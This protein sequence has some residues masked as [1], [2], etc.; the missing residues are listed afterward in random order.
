MD[1]SELLGAG[2]NNPVFSGG[3]GLAILAV[4][5]SALRSSARLSLDLLKRHFVISLEVTSKDKAYPWILQWISKQGS[6]T[7]HLSVDTVV[8]NIGH[9]TVQ[10]SFDF[11]PGPG[12]HFIRYRGHFMSVQRIREQQMVDLNTGKPWEKVVFL[13]LGRSTLLF[14]S[15]LREA[16]DNASQQEEGKMIIFTNW[17]AEWRPFGQPRRRRPLDSVILDEGISKK[18]FDDVTNWLSAEKWYAERGIPYRRGYLL[19]GPPGSG[20]TSYIMVKFFILKYIINDF[21]LILL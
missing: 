11:V 20:K 5:A 14:E 17:G 1:F 9:N 15:I 12:Q 16:Y 2:S 21:E 10:T 8:R 6:R 13:S 19:H 7:Q 3:F 18:I 4:G